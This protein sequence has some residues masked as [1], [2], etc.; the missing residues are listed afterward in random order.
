MRLVI[1]RIGFDSK[2]IYPFARLLVVLPKL[3]GPVLMEP[4][5]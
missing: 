2:M 3:F 1:G 4:S 5:T